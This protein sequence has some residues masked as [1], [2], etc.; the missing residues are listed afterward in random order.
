MKWTPKQKEVIETRDLDILVSAAAGSG[1]TAVLTARILKLIEEGH[2]IDDFLVI[3]FTRAAAED[4]RD[5]I[6]KRLFE[7]ARKP[8]GQYFSQELKKL[9]RAQ[10]STI[11]SFCSAVI[12]EN[13]H[14]IG[15]ASCR[16]RV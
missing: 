2:S 14:E 6:R 3:T 7:R 4:M 8:G 11:H 12:R 5:K 13:F 10:I 16:E 9:P 15:R 1:K